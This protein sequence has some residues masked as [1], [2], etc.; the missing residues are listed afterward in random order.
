MTTKE[1]WQLHDNAPALY[2]RY[3]VPTLF[4]PW[5]QDLL[6]TANLRPGERVLDVACG[7][8]SVTRL[9]GPQI[10]PQGQLTALDLNAEM[11]KAAHTYVKPTAPPIRWLH[12]DLVEMPVD[13]ADFDVV[14]CQQSFQFFPD[15]LGALQEM[16]RVL[17]SSGR[18]AF[19]ISRDL[20]HNP[21]IRALADGLEHH[22][23]ANG[24]ESMRAPCSFGDAELLR[25]LLRR[26]GFS[27]INIGISILTIRHPNPNEFI[28]G[29][30]AATPV[31]D[32]VAALGK[33]QQATLVAEILTSLRDY[34]DDNGLAVPY[35]THVVLARA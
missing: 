13:D 11:L 33:I 26:A 5:A 15:K 10:G 21:Y 23:G 35:E 7:T 18:L 8:G 19:N 20:A 4:T 6:A 28:Y 9:I 16:Q 2:E 24:G 32:Q 34:T 12:A 31:A 3:L 29:Q 22:I 17:K 30:L 27:A 1:A 25:A 14:L